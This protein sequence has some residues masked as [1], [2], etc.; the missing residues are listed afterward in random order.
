MKFLADNSQVQI[1]NKL[2]WDNKL[3][4]SAK[5][6]LW[7]ANQAFHVLPY[8]HQLSLKFQTPESPLD[9]KKIKPVSPKR[10]QPWVFTGRTNA[11]AEAPVVNWKL[12]WSQMTH[13]KSPWCREWLMAEEERERGWDGWMASPMQW[14]WTW[15]NTRAWWRTGRPGVLQSTGP[16]RVRQQQQAP[17][18]LV[19]RMVWGW[20]I[21]RV[22]KKKKKIWNLQTVHSFCTWGFPHCCV[23]YIRKALFQYCSSFIMCCQ[24]LATTG[25]WLFKTN[26]W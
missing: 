2:R 9:S 26:L 11:E 13:W 6:R 4:P 18:C 12:W 7:S 20:D 10:D 5:E 14:T 15:A 25:G 16:Q 21:T 3:D 23:C 17:R 22:A 24:L 19:N 1:K 8:K